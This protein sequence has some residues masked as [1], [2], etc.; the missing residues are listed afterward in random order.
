MAKMNRELA[1]LATD[2]VKGRHR[3]AGAYVSHKLDGLRA[4][5]LPATRGLNV[6][7]IPFANRGKD[8]REHVATGLWSRYGKVIHC[9]EWFVAGFPDHP[10]DGELWCG[11]G[12]F[13]KT[14]SIVKNMQ[15]DRAAEWVDVRYMVF[16]RPMYREV[17]ADGRISNLQYKHTMSLNDNMFALRIVRAENVV[18]QDSHVCRD[19]QT[20][21]NFDDRYKLLKKDMVETEY[22][23]LHEQRLLPFSTPDALAIIEAELESVTATGGEGLILRQ[24]ASRWEPVR[25]AFM[26]KLKLLKDAEGMV[27]GV[28]SGQGKHLGRMGSL[29][30]KCD[31]L[32]DGMVAE[33]DL[34]GFTDAERQL[35][36]NAYD[37]AVANPGEMIPHTSIGWPSPEFIENQMITFRYRELTNDGLPKEARYWRKYEE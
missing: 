4:L 17:F 19:F 34:S 36:Q 18:S 16:D 10:L 33:F 31:T 5:W 7:N 12:Q 28:R 37:W 30:V 14:A 23:R 15:A 9:P 1:M 20:A 32:K 29:K 2:Y 27:I 22:L 25:S 3:V 26:H 6:A 21:E 11:C 8:Q 24:I 13:Q 35:H